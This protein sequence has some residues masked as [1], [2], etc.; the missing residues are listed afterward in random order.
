MER[1][2]FGMML[3]CA[4][5]KPR[6]ESYGMKIKTISLAC[7]LSMCAGIAEAGACRPLEYAEIRDTPSKELVE[8]Y[9]YYGAL[10]KL[11]HDS[12][13]A[14]PLNSYAAQ[15]RA[16]FSECGDL[17]SKIATALKAKHVKLSCAGTKFP[18]GGWL[19]AP[20]STTKK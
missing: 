2:I 12:A 8:T 15:W 9:C 18:E 11:A 4:G 7:S 10:G 16:D 13:M 17:Q 3:V 5:R 19:L 14:N 6:P 20:D 1:L